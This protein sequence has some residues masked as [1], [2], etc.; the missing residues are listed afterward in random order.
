[1]FYAPHFLYKEDSVQRRDEF[2]RVQDNFSRWLL[3]G[4]CRCDDKGIG[5]PI[6]V[7]GR[8]YIPQYHI[9]CDKSKVQAGDKIRVL[10]QDG[11]VRAEG[12]VTVV[13]KCNYLNYMNLYV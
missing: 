10:E 3:V 5:H 4:K 11:T 1:M 2:N 7:N 13:N 8:E 9:V 6:T 12:K